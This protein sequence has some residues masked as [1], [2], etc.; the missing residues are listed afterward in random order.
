LSALDLRRPPQPLKQLARVHQR[1]IDTFGHADLRSAL[2]APLRQRQ[3]RPPSVP[4]RGTDCR[5][6]PRVRLEPA[7]SV[8]LQLDHVGSRNCCVRLRLAHGN[9]L[10]W[11]VAP[12]VGAAR[13]RFIGGLH[14]RR[15]GC[16]P[17]AAHSASRACSSSSRIAC[18]PRSSAMR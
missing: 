11:A 16:T 15:T 7:C 14:A 2:L 4:T 17:A 3:R 1:A 13:G 9:H 8:P 6:R 12:A 5:T 10:L 18:S